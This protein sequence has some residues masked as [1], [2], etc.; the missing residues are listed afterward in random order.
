MT[1]IGIFVDGGYLSEVSKYYRFNH[2]KQA[3]INPSGLSIFAKRAVAEKLGVEESTCVITEAHY[4]RGRFSAQSTEAHGTLLEERLFDDMLLRANFIPHLTLMDESLSFVREKA[5]DTGLVVE[6]LDL[7]MQAKYDVLVLVGCDEDFVPLISKLHGKGISTCALL[8]SFQYTFV[9]NGRE[10]SRG[11]TA[12]TRLA[13]S[14]MWP[15]PMSELIH[16]QASH[17]NILFTQ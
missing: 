8:W 14:I 11:V 12:S 6:A 5:V 7:A 1:K 17:T 2:P 10:V 13:D 9:S 15:L 4:F 3:W 16:S